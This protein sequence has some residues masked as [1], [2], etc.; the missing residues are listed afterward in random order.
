MEGKYYT[1]QSVNVYCPTVEKAVD[2]CSHY[3]TNNERLLLEVPFEQ[4]EE[5]I[6]VMK[7]QVSDTIDYRQIIKKGAFTYAQ[8]EHITL[9]RNIHGLTMD[10]QGRIHFVNDAISISA[11]TAFAQ[12]KWNGA[13]RKVAI[14]NGIH[15]GL[16]VLGETFA[17]EVISL[18]I[19]NH[20]EVIADFDLN[21]DIRGAFKTGGAKMAS[22]KM[23]TAITKKAMISSAALKKGIM[24]LNTN[25]VTGALVT[26]MMST[27]DIAH[28][29]RGKMS[30]QQL[31]KNIAKTAASV[32]GGMIGML[33]G[34]GIGLTIPN[35]ST[36]IVS[37]IGAIVGL[38]IG[39][40]LASKITK[41][42]LDMFI[43]DDALQMLDIFNERLTVLAGEYLL[44]EKELEQALHDFEALHNM[45]KML[46]EMYAAEDR[47]QFADQL[48]QGELMRIVK[49]RMYLHVPTNEEIYEVLQPMAM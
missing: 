4:Y 48:I 39:S 14:E 18:Q 26:G 1:N 30:S 28:T 34:S 12:S 21:P 41:R 10:E 9:A 17:E 24:L 32:T 27:V 42:A 22:K 47:E 7:Q 8:I 44:N 35:V 43:R 20:E 37:M 3:I 16:A 6:N 38:L 15:T 40:G 25:V 31:F 46:K 33:V 19:Y 23:A 29:V 5:I 11:V 13:P 45:P 2:I 49:L 36:A